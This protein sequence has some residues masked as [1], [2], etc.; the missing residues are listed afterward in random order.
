MEEITKEL[1]N[2]VWWITVVIA[3]IIINI[4]AA[5][6]FKKMEASVSNTSSKLNRLTE[7][8]RAERDARIELLKSDKQAVYLAS[9]DEIRNR[10]RMVQGMVLG[11]SFF[12]FIEFGVVHLNIPNPLVAVMAFLSALSISVGWVSHK[13]S[14]TILSEIHESQQI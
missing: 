13:K 11:V 8:R 9:L 7:Q 14:M 1:S 6:I 10:I 2:P 5:F 12:V 4:V 3:G